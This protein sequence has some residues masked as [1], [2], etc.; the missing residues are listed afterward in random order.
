[1]PLDAGAAGAADAVDVVGRH[2][3]Q[4]EV[5]DVRELLDVEA[6]RRDLGRDQERRRGRP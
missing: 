3:R 4:L 6:A 5:D 2:H 1:M